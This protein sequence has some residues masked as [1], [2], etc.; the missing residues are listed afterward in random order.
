MILY[1]YDI[2]N[3]I[4]TVMQIGRTCIIDSLIQLIID[5][6]NY[7]RYENNQ[8]YVIDNKMTYFIWSVFFPET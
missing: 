1:V 3:K 7:S 5:N 8:H 2:T 6:Y 4:Q